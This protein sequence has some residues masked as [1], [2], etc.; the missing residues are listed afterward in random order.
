MKY[1]LVRALEESFPRIVPNEPAHGTCRFLPTANI[2]GALTRL[3]SLAWTDPS[4]DIRQEVLAEHPDLVMICVPEDHPGVESEFD[5]W[6]ANVSAPSRM[7]IMWVLMPEAERP[8]GIS[9][10]SIVGECVCDMTDVTD[11]NVWFFNLAEGGIGN[12]FLDLGRLIKEVCLGHRVS[13][14]AP[15]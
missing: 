2:F 8:T 3:V 11:G 7:E 14:V 9:L 13:E 6:Q 15:T 1:Q 5:L 10:G 12:S 4:L